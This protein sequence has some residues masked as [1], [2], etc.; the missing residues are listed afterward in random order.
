WASLLPMLIESTYWVR[1]QPAAQAVLRRVLHAP[2]LDRRSRAVA[3][4]CAAD[5]GDGLTTSRA[6]LAR[7]SIALFDEIGDTDPGA[8][9]MALVYLAEDHLDAGLGLADDLL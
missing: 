4:A 5:V 7:E 9:S 1:G 2:E 3:L 6:D 8:L